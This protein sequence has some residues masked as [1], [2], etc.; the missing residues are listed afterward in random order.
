MVGGGG[1]TT[2]VIAKWMGV[3]A[4]GWAAM[5]LLVHGLQGF[6]ESQYLIDRMK[7]VAEGARPYKDFEF[8]YG[9][10]FLYGPRTLMFLRL[11]AEQGYFVFWLM[12]LLGGVWMLAKILEMLDY[13]SA[14][15]SEI[16]NLFCLFQLPVLLC[17]GLNYSFLRF[18]PAPYF[19]LLVQ[20]MDARGGHRHRT[21]AMLMAVAFTVVLLMVSPEMALAY[22]IGT[23]GYFAVFGRWDWRSAATYATLVIG[24]AVVLL[25][26]NRMDVFATMKAFSGG[27]NNFPIIPAGHILFFFFMCG[28]VSIF[29]AARLR[30]GSRGDGMLMVVAV[31]TGTLFAALGRCD[32]GHV[33]LAAVGIVIVA[34]VLASTFPRIWR[35]Y[36]IAFLLFFVFFPT[37]T[38]IWAYRILLSK[39]AVVR[40]FQ[41]EPQGSLTRMDTIIEHGMQLEYG[42]IKARSK[43]EKLKANSTIPPEID[44]QSAYPQLEGKLMTPFGYTPLGFGSYHS[45]SIDMGY[46]YGLSNLFTP[47]MVERKIDELQAYPE[48]NLLL[49]ENFNDSCKVDATAERRLIQEIFVYPYRAKVRHSDTVREPLCSYIDENYQEKIDLVPQGYG[50]SVWGIR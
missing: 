47:A 43:F 30:T 36:R 14:H 16:F 23:L 34:T 45:A 19:G 1:I 41:G 40:L 18:L 31:S 25:E 3:F 29:V 26:A 35:V 38:S 44:L 6:G 27:A 32:E 2:R 5:Y 49:P 28:L 10:L 7:M 22:G 21:I 50:Y 8:A 46:F 17:T 37:V 39:I 33:V 9:V 20:R 4:V 13:P 24:E 12:W 15:K 11:S 48:R 42:E